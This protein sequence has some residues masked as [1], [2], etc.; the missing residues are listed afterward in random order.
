MALAAE[1]IDPL[2][3]DLKQEEVVQAAQDPQSNIP[4]ET[5]ERILVEKSRKAG[6]V[7]YQF[8]PNATPEQKDEQ[9]KMTIPTNFHRDKKP[10]PVAVT[11]DVI[12]G[13]AVDGKTPTTGKTDGQLSPLPPKPSTELSEEERW[14]RDRTGWAPRFHIKEDEVDEG[15]IL[16]D[17]QTLLESKL[18]ENLFG[19]MSMDLLLS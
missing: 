5:A 3:G 14:A 19:G 12:N 10:S 13:T 9:V 7:A 4:P 2:K 18:D 16:L 17:H 8:D 15:E 11:T 1:H 6:S